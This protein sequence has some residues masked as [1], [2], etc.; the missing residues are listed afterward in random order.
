MRR[1]L[2]LL[3]PLLAAFHPAPETSARRHDVHVS[4]GRM[5]VE[6]NVALVQVRLFKDDLTQALTGLAGR[7][8]TLAPTPEMDAL[9]TRYLNR[10]LLVNAGGRVLVGRIVGSEEDD[11]M[12]AYQVEYRATAPIRS[13]VLTNTLLFDLYDDQRNL[14]RVMFFP[15]E[16]TEAF[17][18]VRGAERYEIRL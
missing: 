6:G 11:D 10:H 5:A 7:A 12:W 13:L 15:S 14:F 4:N 16:K 18:F 17:Y 3:L 1:L 8:V 2:F 9:A